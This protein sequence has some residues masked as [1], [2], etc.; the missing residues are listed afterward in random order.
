MALMFYAN[1]SFQRDIAD[2]FGISQAAFSKN[3]PPVSGAI[4]ELADEW[5]QMPDVNE[6]RLIQNEFHRIANFPGWFY[7]QYLYH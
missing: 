5:I 1:G 7:L 3:L 2:F 6:R 4:A